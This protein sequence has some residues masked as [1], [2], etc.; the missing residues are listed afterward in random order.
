MDVYICDNL[1]E[2]IKRSG[3][4]VR[5]V[6]PDGRKAQFTLMEE[7]L[8]GDEFAVNVL[9]SPTTPR[10]VQ[11]TDVWKY[12]KI[13]ADGTMVNTWQ[14]MVDPHNKRYASLVRYAEGIARAC[15]IKYGMGHVEIKAIYDEKADKYIDPVMIEV[16][17][18]LAGGRKAIMA[19]STIPGWYP[20]DAMLDAHCGFPVRVPHS[21]TP[22]KVARHVFVPSDK[23]GI[24]KSIKGDDFKRLGTYDSCQML[25]GVGEHVVRA[26]DLLS[27]AGFV[28]LIG[29]ME[30]V[31][32]D[33][34]L[35]RE[36]F[37]VEVEDNS[38]EEKKA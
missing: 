4:I 7:F 22:A 23:E 15:G 31:E 36:E 6:G 24:I 13:Q 32:R 8:Q 28:W 20:F 21:F 10:G 11:V 27:F 5:S 3:Q 9:A 38:E 37:V 12:D 26:R 16:G 17:A 14:T 34:L 2:A 1:E 35:A 25:K 18:R 30:V 33:S 29:D 19:Q